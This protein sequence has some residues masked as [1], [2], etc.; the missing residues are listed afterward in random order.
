MLSQFKV[1]QPIAYK[2]LTKALNKQTF[3]HA[4]LF[5]TNGYDKGLKF[6]IEFAKAILCPS[7]QS[8]NVD[9][10][11]CY[12]CNM[13]DEN[14]FTEL[15]IIEA[16]GMWIKKEQLIDLQE[17]F[18]KKAIIGQK[19]VYIIHGAEKLNLNSANSILKFLEEPQEGVIAILVTDNQYQLLNTILSRCQ[20][21][22][23][24]GQK[25]LIQSNNTFSKI[26]QLLTDNEIDYNQ[27]LEDEKNYDKITGIINFIKCYEK[28]G[29]KMLLYLYQYWF[30][31]FSDKESMSKA[32]VVLLNFYKDAL[33]QKIGHALEIFIDK[34]YEK[35]IV[36]LAEKNTISQIIQK[37]NSIN[38]SRQNLLYNANLNLLM[39]KLILDME[40][41]SFVASSRS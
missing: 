9:C 7:H 15:K 24:N 14:N 41:D 13:I 37:I 31:L 34:E 16:D 39:D 1:E 20:I 18:S 38:Q 36:W 12:Q 25:D 40:G 11:E 3:S 22:S 10:H 29:K 32:F 4:Y 27:F 23:L 17:E 5:E 19:K 6:A 21:I 33:N 8:D 30:T 2:I 26:G 28:N 35:D